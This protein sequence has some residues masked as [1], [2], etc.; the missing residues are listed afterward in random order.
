MLIYD[1]LP[2]E[3][4]FERA[5][6]WLFGSPIDWLAAAAAAACDCS[7]PDGRLEHGSARDRGDAIVLDFQWAALTVASPFQRFEGELQFAPLLAGSHLS[8]SGS[9]EPRAGAAGLRIERTQI[10]R[11]TEARVRRFLDVV[12]GSMPMTGQSP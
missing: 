8:L 6:D 9:Y 3:W 11:E 5:A 4:P 7:S 1:F 10:Q 2:L 12:A